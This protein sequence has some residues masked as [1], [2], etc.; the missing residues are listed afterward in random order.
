[1]DLIVFPE[2]TLGGNATL[3]PD[4]STQTIPC[5]SS[6]DFEYYLK[7]LSCAAAQRKSYLVVNLKEKAICNTETQ[8]SI[9]DKRPCSSS[10]YNLYNTNV[11]F[12]R[13]GAVVSRYRKYNLFGEFSLNTTLTPDIS[14]F[15]TD[16]NVTFGLFTCFDILFET[17]AL[18]LTRQ[19]VDNIIFPTMWFSELPFLTALQ[20]QQMFSVATN[21]NFLSSGANS[22]VRGSGGTGIFQGVHGPV[23]YD[24][25]ETGG[26][27]VYI[28]EVGN[29]PNVLPEVNTVD[30][31]NLSEEEI[32]VHAKAMDDFTLI[33]DQVDGKVLF[34]I[35]VSI[36]FVFH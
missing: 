31:F 15:T 34:I 35:R 3:V 2:Y 27:K 7:Q 13:N 6:E 32:D 1:M 25:V 16:F 4:G 29:S 21:V 10:G 19:N 20:A 17:P 26:T 14:T 18:A 9:G 8:A 33:R 11:A 5:N 28:A 12:D 22:P 30:Y 36:I 23:I 24:Y